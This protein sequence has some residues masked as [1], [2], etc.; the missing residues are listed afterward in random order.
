MNYIVLLLIL[1]ANHCNGE[2]IYIVLLLVLQLAN[3]CNIALNKETL[4]LLYPLANFEH[5][6]LLKRL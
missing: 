2:M 5:H 6:R 3:H 1:L 4:P